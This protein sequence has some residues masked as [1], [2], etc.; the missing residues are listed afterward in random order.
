MSC[1]VVLLISFS[2]VWLVIMGGLGWRFKEKEYVWEF[3][4]FFYYPLSVVGY[5]LLALSYERTREITR[6][7]QQE[8][9]MEYRL[10]EFRRQQPAQPAFTSTDIGSSFLR[11][12]Y[13]GTM[14]IVKMGQ[15]CEQSLLLDLNENKEYGSPLNWKCLRAR[16]DGAKT[17]QILKGF[18]PPDE[19]SELDVMARS[20]EDF[21]SRGSKLI[22]ALESVGGINSII[23]GELKQTFSELA[24]KN[25]PSIDW[26]TTERS[27]KAFL[28]TIRAKRDEFISG[29]LPEYQVMAREQWDAE[30]FTAGNV[31]L[32]FTMCLRIP[33][34]YKQQ[35]ETFD[36]WQG[37][38]KE[39]RQ[40][41]DEQK[42]IIEDLQK[43]PPSPSSMETRVD[44][45]KSDIWPFFIVLALGLKFGKGVATV[46]R[47]T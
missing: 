23:Y 7:N 45:L 24:N 38:V 44:K 25:L 21:C 17:D 5:I 37:T 10:E 42:R 47:G 30:S 28:D 9:E 16:D 46:R 1:V 3:A 27:R 19:R 31:A 29:T 43:T 39:I 6:L 40:K 32:S 33:S 35:K 2:L 15:A 26:S 20:I 36:R 34:A 4:D 41:A 14:L 22:D 18:Q 8:A 12:S 13:D 11:V